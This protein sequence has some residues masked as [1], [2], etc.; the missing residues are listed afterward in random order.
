M[1]S[2][3][4]N[5]GNV[6]GFRTSHT[7]QKS[8]SGAAETS[9]KDTATKENFNALVQQQQKPAPAVKPQAQEVSTETY[10]PLMMRYGI[11][12]IQEIQNIAEDCGINDL[13]AQ[14]Y[15]YAIRYGRSLLADYLV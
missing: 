2:I 5:V 13:T 7:L 14:D 10:S 4:N 15:D 1:V 8:R 6:G 11:N 12:K 3:Q 9:T